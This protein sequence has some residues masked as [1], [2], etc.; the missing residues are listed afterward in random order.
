VNDV[1]KWRAVS[2]RILEGESGG[3]ERKKKEWE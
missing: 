1:K 3:R 2:I